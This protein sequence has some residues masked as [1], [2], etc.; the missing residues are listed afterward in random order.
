MTMSGD[1]TEPSAP[2]DLRTKGRDR[3][4]GGGG[5][6]GSSGGGSGSSSLRGSPPASPAVTADSGA[7]V[8]SEPSLIKCGSD[9]KPPASDLPIRKR[10]L[11]NHSTPDPS[12]TEPQKDSGG[13]PAPAKKPR[14]SVE[15]R[16]G[17]SRAEPRPRSFSP[18]Q[19]PEQAGAH[20]HSHGHLPTLCSH[21]FISTHP[22]SNIYE[23]T[24]RL[25]REVALATHPDDDGDTPL[26]IAV[27]QGKL[28][29]V[30]RLIH[31]FLRGQKE[32]DSYNNLRQ[33]PLHLAVITH[34]HVMVLAL[35]KGGADP[36]A[37]DRNGQTALHLCCEHGQENCLSVILSHIARSSCCP[38]TI[39]DSR[40]YEGLTPLHLAV[41][42]GKK[43]LA[44]M[45]LDSG[46]DIN[47]VDIKS[48]RSPLM[49]AVENNC[50]EMVNFLI[51]NGCN[52]NAQS[53]S[54]NTALHSAC[55]RGEV[56]AVRVL[57]KNGAD[58]SLKNYHNDTAVMVAKNKKVS[59]VLRGKTTRGHILKTQL[60][61][62][63]A[64]S[65]VNLSPSPLATTSLH[66]SASVSPVAPC[67]HSPHSQS[68]ES[69]TG[70]HSPTDTQEKEDLQRSTFHNMTAD[71]TDY[72]MSLHS[73]PFFSPPRYDP[74]MPTIL[75]GHPAY[76]Q[77]ALQRHSYSPDTPFIL[78]PASLGRGET[79]VS[80]GLPP[81]S[82]QSRPPS[83]NS[84]SDASNMSV[85]SEG[86]GIS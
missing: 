58:S 36:G 86:K 62:N 81:T 61:F 12:K 67:T 57:L 85:S 53:Y 8:G 20:G 48:G 43:N 59:D 56:D 76:Y 29:V 37:F 44:K 40:N 75:P 73:Y 22:Y 60:S 66:R 10:Y 33:T 7:K 52:V 38:H 51:E 27:V 54:G 79:L 35:L 55:G 5:G 32:L 72:G 11:Q 65:P 74:F 28:S 69:M 80:H 77:A 2:L 70:N 26:H 41:Q 19:S 34:Q 49:H 30:E 18:V 16:N 46:A 64:P 47:A 3:V 31:I 50:L 71:R 9:Q 6:S 45:L 17:L 13:S 39:L 63:G 24:N 68:G 84:E 21:M 78:F 1:R 83:R 14:C 42:D 25:L 82:T 23:D 15:N 4:G